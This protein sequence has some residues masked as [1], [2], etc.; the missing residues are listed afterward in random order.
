M[1]KAGH[2]HEIQQSDFINLNIDLNIHGV[3]GNDSWGARTLDK[4]TNPGNKPYRYGFI[5]EYIK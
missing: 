4:Y 1:E 3:G 5:I 2:P